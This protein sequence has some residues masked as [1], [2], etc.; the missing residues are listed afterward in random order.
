VLVS[1]SQ[2][3][4]LSV[5]V[6]SDQVRDIQKKK[7]KKIENICAAKNKQNFATSLKSTLFPMNMGPLPQNHN[8]LDVH[9]V[10]T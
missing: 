10:V 5:P 1:S 2:T 7:K 4:D 9:F 3:Q 6:S 8:F